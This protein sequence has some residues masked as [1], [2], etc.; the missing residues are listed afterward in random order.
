M[1]LRTLS[2]E[3]KKTFYVYSWFSDR[4]Y[5]LV[6]VLTEWLG[7]HPALQLDAGFK[8]DVLRRDSPEYVTRGWE[9]TEALLG[10]F[11]RTTETHGARFAAVIIPDD[12]QYDAGRWARVREEFKLQERDFDLDKSSTL[13]HAACAR[14]GIPCLDLLPVFRKEHAKR[15]LTLPDDVHGNPWGHEVVARELTGFLADRNLLGS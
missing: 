7:M 3:L 14:Q 13:V 2:Y 8:Q 9:L 15:S 12:L 4:L 5:M 11:K 6:H 1:E 10:E